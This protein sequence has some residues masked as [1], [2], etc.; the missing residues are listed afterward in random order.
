MCCYATIYVHRSVLRSMATL[1]VA[2]MFVV[3][4][5]SPVGIRH[6]DLVHVR[7]KGLKSVDGNRGSRGHE[8]IIRALQVARVSIIAAGEPVKSTP[9]ADVCGESHYLQ[10]YDQALRSYYKR[11][12]R[13]VLVRHEHPHCRSV[14][15]HHGQG[16]DLLGWYN[17]GVR[18]DVLLLHYYYCCIP[19]NHHHPIDSLTT[20]SKRA[21]RQLPVVHSR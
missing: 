8:H 12:G 19:Q 9:E 21:E 17:L 6:R 10:S 5:S 4:T 15:W 18:V 2:H 14:F 11:L 3:T 16:M 1:V 13:R 7:Q 20:L